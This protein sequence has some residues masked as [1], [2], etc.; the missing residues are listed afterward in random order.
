[1]KKFLTLSL[2]FLSALLGG[3]RVMAGEASFTFTSK[4]QSNSQTVN[5]ITV[6]FGGSTSDQTGYRRFK[7]SATMAV[8]AEPGYNITSVAITFSTTNGKSIPTTTQITVNPTGNSYAESED[9]LT[10]T[11]SASSL[12]FTKDA[13]GN[14]FDIV[15][16]SVTYEAASQTEWSYNIAIED[17]RLPHLTYGPSRSGIYGLNINASGWQSYS[18]GDAYGLILTSGSGNK[19]ITIT[20]N[21]NNITKVVLAGAEGAFANTT[22]ASENT[23]P[24]TK[25]D[26]IVWQS[27]T[28]ATSVT[29]SIS[30]T[31]RPTFQNIYVFTNSALSTTK[32]NVT[33]SF[34]PDEGTAKGGV[35]DYS[36][37]GRVKATIGTGGTAEPFRP[38]DFTSNS[39][40]GAATFNQFHLSSGAV[41]VN[42][43]SSGGSATISATFDGTSNPFYNTASQGTYNLTVE[44]DANL[45]SKTISINDMRISKI[46][47]S[48]GLTADYNN[49]DRTLGGFAFTFTGGEG[50]KFN[51]GDGIYLRTYDNASGTITITPQKTDNNKA[52]K[53]KQVDIVTHPSYTN[54]TITYTNQSTAQ[55]VQGVSAYS[56]Q[57]NDGTDVFTMTSASGD[58]YIEG[59]T[60]Y[61]TDADNT[62][63]DAPTT[64]TF[65]WSK[66]SDTN[67]D[68]NSYAS[69]ALNTDA[70]FKNFDINI[71]SNNTTVA[72]IKSND[73]NN[74]PLVLLQGATGDATITAASTASTYYNAS[75]S[76]VY[77]IGVTSTSSSKKWDFTTATA[78]DFDLTSKWSK[79][80]DVYLSK[81]TTSAAIKDSQDNYYKGFDTNEETSVFKNLWVGNYNKEM[82]AK[83]IRWSATDYLYF[84]NS[85]VDVSVPV[86]AGQSVIITFD[87]KDGKSGGFTFTN[88]TV[89][90][91]ADA[92]EV[93]TSDGSKQTITLIATAD[94]RVDFINKA[95]NVRLHSI[96][97]RSETRATLA[98]RDKGSNTYEK[99]VGTGTESSND[100]HFSHGVVF[101]P[102]DGAA[103]PVT[104]AN[105]ASKF[106]ITSSDPTVLDVSKAYVVENSFG[107]SSSFYFANVKPVGAGTA[108]LTITFEGNNGYK[109]NSYT[110]REY[111]VYG[112][113]STFL[114]EADDQ[115]IQR[116][117]FSQIT[118]II[119]DK[120]GNPLGIKQMTD[121]T[122]RYTTYILG[123]EDDMP[124]YTMYFDFTYT[125]AESG[126]GTNWS[127][128]KVDNTGKITTE[129]D[130]THVA[131]PGATRKITIAATPKSKYK[132][133]FA[134]STAVTNDLTVTIIEKTA[135][136]QLEF[137][138]DENCT[139]TNKVTDAQY[140]I[141]S[142]QWIFN[143]GIFAKGFP[144]G[145]ILY[146]KAKNEGNTIWFSYAQDAE[147]AVIPANPSVDKKKRI[148]QYRRGIPIY[149]DDNLSGS[150][151]IC[152]NAV[153]ATYDAS[154]KKYNLNGSVQRM[155]FPVIVAHDR[156][157]EPTYDPVSPSATTSENKDGRKIMNTAQNVVAYGDGASKNVTGQ[158]NI[159]YGKFSTSN[160][161]TTE[162][163][164]NEATVSRGIDNVPV[165]ST[166]VN[167]RRF[168]AVQVKNFTSETDATYGYGDY[169]SPQT[170][171]EYYYLY[172]TDLRITP[173]QYN[174]S[175]YNTGEN[176][177]KSGTPTYTVTWYNK[178]T[179]K[180]QEVDSYAGKITY[181]IASRNGASNATLDTS[182]GVVT[183]GNEPGW[184]R[185]KVTYAGG[186]KHGGV[187]GE[188]QYESETDKSEAYYYVYISDPS[189][190]TPI[191]T[192]P[193]RNFTGTLTYKIQAPTNWAVRYTSGKTPNDP[194][195]DS[196]TELAAKGSVTVTIGNDMNIGDTYTVK[197]I[198]YNGDLTSVVVSETYT[199]K[200][201]LPDPI[202]DPD[203]TKGA[204]YVYNTNE[205][206]VQIACAYAGSVI[207]YTIS[208]KDAAE[209]PDP[210]I[211]AEN[212][213]RYS[214]LSKITVT[215][216]KT[217]KAIAYDPVNEIYSNIVTSKYVYSTEMSKPYFQVSDDGGNT[218]K[219]LATE[220][221]STLTEGGTKWY[222]GENITI[223]P[224]TQIRI[225]DPNAVAGTIY[226][227]LDNN[228]TPS[229]DAN[230][231]V[232]IEGYPFTVGKTTTAKAITTLEDASSDVASAVFTIETSKYG[233]VWEAVDE[234]TTGLEGKKGIHK[235]DG[236]IISTDE[237][238]VVK[239]T[240]SKVNTLSLA[241]GNTAEITYAQADITAT[242]GGYDLASWEEM[243]I[244]DAA[245]GT[246][247]GNVGKYS[248]KNISDTG[249]GNGNA[250]DE[251]G[252]NYNHIYSYKTEKDRLTTDNVT[253]ATTHEKTFRVPA[254][255]GF[256]RFEPEK[257]GDL[258]IWCL[259]QG[260]LLYED[261]KY[262]IPNVLRIRPVYLVDEQGKSYQ[263]KTVNGVPQLWSSARLSENWTKIQETAANNNWKN[264]NWIGP[265][266]DDY[267][268]TAA[269]Y[270]QYV[271]VS[272]GK[273][274]QAKPT[275][276]GVNIVDKL[277]EVPENAEDLT[278]YYKKLVNKGPNKTE[279]A[280]IYQMYKA[281]LD[282]NHV[283]VGNPIKPFA[284]HTGS[285]ISLNDNR[286]KDNS[287]DGTGYVL[288]SGGYTKYTFELKAGKTYYF[289][290][291]GSKIGIRGFQFVPTETTESRTTLT[292]E[293]DDADE[294]SNINYGP[295]NTEKP[296][297]VKLKR[298]FKANTWAA[299][300]LPFSV[301][302]TQLAK[303][304]GDGVDV[305]HFDDIT[306]NG[307]NIHLVRHWYKMLVAG[308][309]V[310]IRPTIDISKEDG[311]TFKGVRIE[312]EEVETITGK[313]DS[314]SFMGTFQYNET[315]IQKYDYY[316]NGK[317]NFS[318][319]KNSTSTP[320]KATRAWLRPKNA[321]AGAK[322][323]TTD[324]SDFFD[325]G[326]ITGIISIENDENSKGMTAYDGKIYDIKGQIVSLDGDTSKL[327]KGIYISNGQK[328][329]IK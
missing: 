2:L 85:T 44:A 50:I 220:G 60:I 279:T 99:N 82:G 161:Y 202:F 7:N 292:I 236:F 252:T 302:Q 186:E 197:A 64:P 217:I 120:E 23:Y 198:A 124:D 76:Q 288:A 160:V 20:S 203:G 38:D 159:V 49:L 93:S 58:I 128:I 218:W 253:A 191:I 162:Q 136:V 306:N 51:N 110:S 199:K 43:S 61:Y 272:D 222:G 102:S 195:K 71:T 145:R 275:G 109:P 273:L 112:P 254:I 47:N 108:T 324:F 106:H 148:F 194:T 68:A 196:G 28:P 122:N 262:F 69:P 259:Q 304:F 323:L 173:D 115:E 233:N 192:P 46:A 258:T 138:W 286:L 280:A 209:K 294:T 285:T 83:A 33:L 314:Y 152:I 165:V 32:Q 325:E 13:T 34:T 27:T 212:T 187:S 140:D 156:P 181:S 105:D 241:T 326:T 119:T 22:I 301:S 89:E 248:I 185:V 297:D 235:N 79:S 67:V 78:S 244:A 271:R 312:T 139:E 300:V 141:E 188:P 201:P 154:T 265:G 130:D 90:G 35:T 296:I 327:P 62:L 135:D 274:E 269:E 116:G 19:D 205:L 4:W 208:D 193:T 298:A 295:T 153:E 176:P 3:N 328:F 283:S 225:V 41:G 216:E 54:G 183:A 72:T 75:E 224:S 94:G 213:Y 309:P 276:D 318:Q 234:T 321:A 223:T 87:T 59:F 45:K 147:A 239:N 322:Q 163:L 8:S 251:S 315:G 15:G 126:S 266:N 100:N 284:I 257:D 175:I 150:N 98:L 237:S 260:A 12:T 21:S 155:K 14:E 232:Y 149:I 171:T 214:G 5:P 211:G 131:E 182:T 250:K 125:A 52:V 26:Q 305:L 137:Y 53:I 92:T 96:I 25:Q 231:F 174:I 189:K 240:G 290:A 200:A 168:T 80:G 238:L 215:G 74:S 91:D 113:Q 121:G 190:E 129:D 282:K 256:V 24:T 73:R 77:T 127:Y 180:N 184:V 143:K 303:A 1:M 307:G 311:V 170:Y 227:T 313:D 164:I 289:F 118:P 133:A 268:V 36:I 267:N 299:L 270:V 264:S 142:K 310:L 103:N 84:N 157:A 230:S 281:D 9:H 37:D 16:I 134:S 287:D 247:I 167:K 56:M 245:T 206:T 172:D 277:S 320:I 319:L 291:Q 221:G 243:K 111:T 151:Y 66:T 70:P 179:G 39:V 204:G 29:I 57:L 123:E 255:G 169:I 63:N 81:F 88:A 158:N 42:T 114:V 132:T 293:A 107:T 31:D 178:K 278:K 210:V 101:T 242:F 17:L 219:G 40:T 97:V 263:V 11:G 65:S 308:T 10:W 86:A 117:Q 104:F 95:T 316:I 207:Y 48:N 166:E 177:Y 229:N 146:V 144:N 329:V 30:A 55:P 6:T 228:T 226:Y 246:P 261:D 249:V 317:G 18:T